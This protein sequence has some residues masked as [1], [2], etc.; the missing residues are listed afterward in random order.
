[1]GLMIEIFPVLFFLPLNPINKYLFKIF[2]IQ[3]DLM[4]L[5]HMGGLENFQWTVIFEICHVSH[6]AS[7]VLNGN[8]PDVIKNEFHI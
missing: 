7:L 8:S 5:K 6:S 2:V 4:E 1:M 3:A